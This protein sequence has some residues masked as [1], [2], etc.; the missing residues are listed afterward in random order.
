[1][2]ARL[3]TLACATLLLAACA[4]TTELLRE[5]DAQPPAR[6]GKSLLVVGMS[7]DDAVRARYEDAFVAELVRAGYSGTGSH[8]LV[9]SLR[10]LT[11]AQVREHMAEFSGRADLILHAQLAALVPVRPYDPA[12]YPLGGAPAHARVGGV[13][14][15]LNAPAHADTTAPDSHLV[16]IQSSLYEG[17]T[18]RLLWTL[19]TR[20]HEG[21]SLEVVA[22]S[23]ARFLVG[24]LQRRGYL[25]PV[26]R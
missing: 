1:M 20:T 13:E 3:L 23:H 6:A 25:A 21:N 9:P 16:D 5:V 17:G 10:D 8:E 2:L 11:M 12:D 18:R 14:V 19:F 15:T 22:R 4:P 24:E 26:A 7:P